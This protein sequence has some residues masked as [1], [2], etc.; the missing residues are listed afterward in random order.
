MVPN[1]RHRDASRRAIQHSSAASA[2]NAI[3]GMMRAITTAARAA[4]AMRGGLGHAFPLTGGYL[5]EAAAAN[6]VDAAE[7]RV[8]ADAM[9]AS[10]T[11]TVACMLSGARMKLGGW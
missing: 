10:A 8:Y 2:A 3:P 11:P 5:G 4:G 6:A 1:R 9:A 7:K